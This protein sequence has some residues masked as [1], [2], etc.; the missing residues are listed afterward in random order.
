MTISDTMQKAFNDQYNAEIQA[1][2]I[3]KQLALDLDAL[4]LTGMR[5]WMRAQV[6]EGFD[7]AQR[8]ADHVINR[9]G[10]VAQTTISVP[11][12][13]IKSA[14]DAFEAAFKHEQHVSE[15]IRNLAR[16]AEE[17]GD[18]DSRPLLNDFLNEQIEEEAT[19]SEILDRLNI[20]GND[21]SGLLRI[22]SELGERNS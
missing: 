21:G 15:L 4:S 17:Q 8:F 18:V 3:Y 13:N 6:E 16:T 5:D 22:D 20:V 9:G 11:E 7:H 2:L 10:T 19:V 14:T 1:A 12:L